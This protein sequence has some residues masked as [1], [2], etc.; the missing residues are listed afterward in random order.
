[1][2]C[3]PV[4]PAH[5]AML[6]SPDVKTPDLRFRAGRAF[7]DAADQCGSRAVRPLLRLHPNGAVEPNHFA[8]E[9]RVVEDLLD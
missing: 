4:L 8:V 2:R 7:F 1:M 3:E 5:T 6:P 9:H